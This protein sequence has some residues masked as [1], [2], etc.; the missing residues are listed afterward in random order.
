MLSPGLGKS[1]GVGLSQS[2]PSPRGGQR[3]H[4]RA[5]SQ[6]EGQD[7]CF[8]GLLSWHRMPLIDFSW[9]TEGPP[10]GRGAGEGARINV[11]AQCWRLLEPSEGWGL[12]L[13]PS[14]RDLSAKAGNITSCCLSVC[15][16]LTSP[17]CV[18]TGSCAK[19]KEKGLVTW[20]TGGEGRTVEDAGAG[21]EVRKVESGS[22]LRS[23][24]QHIPGAD[25]KEAGLER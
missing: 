18:L 25:G 24:K 5:E 21:K 7:L 14:R 13:A 9:V 23:W 4:P 12:A 20:I 16:L 17:F 2:P 22:C 11:T 19:M 8:Q 15:S 3:R 6:L 10:L 1:P